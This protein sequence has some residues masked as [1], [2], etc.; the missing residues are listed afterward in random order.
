MISNRAGCPG[1][2]YSKLECPTSHSLRLWKYTAPGGMWEY[3]P[4]GKFKHFHLRLL[5]VVSGDPEGL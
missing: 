2:S 1:N 5:L 3:T 4:T